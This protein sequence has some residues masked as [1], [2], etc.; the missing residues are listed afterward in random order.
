MFTPNGER[1]QWE[2]IYERLSTMDIG[3]VI[4]DE[5]LTGLLPDAPETSVR[6][7]FWRAVKQVED[8]RKRTFDRVRLV[9]YRMVA[10]KE[11]E[12]L[13]RRQHKRAKRRM[14]AAQRKVHSAD[15]SL[16]GSEDRRRLDAIED[17]I[18][19]QME[20][21]RRLDSRQSKTEQRVARTE[22]DSAEIVDRID[23]LT[24]LL[25]RHGIS[26]GEAG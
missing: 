5:E 10:A 9:G 17:H 25:E 16:L 1:P 15:R 4:K 14:A 7:A 23:R 2:V 3:D 11:H 20:M 8:D 13:A 12:G 24:E 21:I 6:G 19:R 26:H 18:G 22:K